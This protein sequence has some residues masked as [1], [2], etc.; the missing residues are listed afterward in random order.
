MAIESLV[1]ID[2]TMWEEFWG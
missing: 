1:L 2:L